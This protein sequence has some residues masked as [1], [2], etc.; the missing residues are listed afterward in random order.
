MSMHIRWHQCSNTIPSPWTTESRDNHKKKH[1]LRQPTQLN[2]TSK[3]LCAKCIPTLPPPI[4]TRSSFATSS[5]HIRKQHICPP[6]KKT[7]DIIQ[8]TQDSCEDRFFLI[9]SIHDLQVSNRRQA[10]LVQ[11]ALHTKSEHDMLRIT[12]NLSST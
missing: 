8:P 10:S 7:L 11:H 6:K 12:M 1:Q 2:L 3:F 4:S 5:L 9:P